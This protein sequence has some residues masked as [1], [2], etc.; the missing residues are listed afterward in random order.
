MT[1]KKA[2]R[3]A[4]RSYVRIINYEGLD[5]WQECLICLIDSLPIC[6]ELFPS[7]IEAVIV[8][9]DMLR[10]FLKAL[11]IDVLLKK[12]IWSRFSNNFWGINDSSLH[13]FFISNIV[14]L[15]WRWWLWRKNMTF[16]LLGSIWILHIL[17]PRGRMRLKGRRCS[18]L[19]LQNIKVSHRV[20]RAWWIKITFHGVRLRISANIIGHLRQSWGFLPLFGHIRHRLLCLLCW[21]LMMM[22]LSRVLGRW[23]IVPCGSSSSSSSRT[24][25][26]LI[27]LEFLLGELGFGVLL[28]NLC[29]LVNCILSLNQFL[30]GLLHYL[31][32]GNLL[33]LVREQVGHGLTFKSLDVLI[34]EL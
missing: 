5:L 34:L 31:R 18:P 1:V 20:S 2:G 11:N 26:L 28:K 29:F 19:R 8:V 25:L 4:I 16:C 10:N 15:H 27:C 33:H 23:G 3:Q 24:I 32:I 12:F 17:I 22:R 14:I 9:I 30:E 6:L 21:T 7:D 13:F